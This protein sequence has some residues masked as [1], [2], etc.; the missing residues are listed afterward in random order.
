MT[1]KFDTVKNNFIKVYSTTIECDI[2]IDK[3]YIHTV[4]Q[5]THYIYN[6]DDITI[7]K[8]ITITE[9]P[10]NNNLIFKNRFT[11][12]PI[13]KFIYI[14][15]HIRFSKWNCDCIIFPFSKESEH[16]MNNYNGL[17]DDTFIHF[18]T[19]E[20]IAN[21]YYLKANIIVLIDKCE[22][23][24]LTLSYYIS[25]KMYEA[26]IMNK[27]VNNKYSYLVDLLE[28]DAIQK[29]NKKAEEEL[30]TILNTPENT[31]TL[32]NIELNELK[33][34]VQLYNYQKADIEW[35]TD[36][37]NNIDNN[38]N[39][40]IVKYTEFYNILL[41]DPYNF[42][43]IKEY[44]LYEG[45]IEKATIK[46]KTIN[47][48][49]IGG[50]I[51]SEIGTGKCHAKDTPILMSDGSIKKVQDIQK[52]ELLMGDDSTPRKV[53]SLARGQ[54]LMYDIIP[55]KGEKYT[56]N[57]AHILCLKVLG[58]PTINITKGKYKYYNIRWVE[59]NKYN[60]KNFPL[61][62]EIEA[63]E[64]LKNVKHQDIIEIAVKD[65]IKLPQNVKNL[66]KGYKVPVDFCEKKLHLDPYMIG[67]WLGDGM[68][69]G[70]EI[71]NQDSTI[72]KYF[73]TNLEQYKC[74]LQFKDDKTNK[75]TYRING[76]G[77]RKTDSNY[78]MNILNK[79]N[80]I[81]NKHIPHIYKCNSRENRLKLLAGLIDSDGSLDS[82]GCY[83]FIQKSEK[84]IDDVIYLAHSLGFACYKSIQKKGCWYLGEY[85]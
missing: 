71:T 24:G 76:D 74:Y 80:L 4:D 67:L 25:K 79:Y 48:N 81:N 82:S 9:E 51:I 21:M 45:I 38:K 11:N 12:L 27:K 58:K 50:N 13:K 40:I 19:N 1:G 44:I 30:I 41:Q 37:K 60:S 14:D 36:I 31:K 35:M 5:I 28:R 10:I 63:K 16:L 69:N 85:K 70:P 32:V 15:K 55:V 18:F 83:D 26:G 34:S 61:N 7:T 3:I 59:N 54:D 56:V 65:Y 52:G 22:D 57:Q 8:T 75:Y 66:L 73:K 43:E 64:F 78:F 39:S 17:Y 68:S 72:I 6:I 2:P 33:N 77:S 42:D 47:I 29:R 49:Y 23:K 20:P 53:L 46:N 62:K 84:L